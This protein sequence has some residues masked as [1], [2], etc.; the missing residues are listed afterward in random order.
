MLSEQRPRAQIANLPNSAQL[1]DTPFHSPKLH[2][3]PCSSVGM[4]QGTNTPTAMAIHFSLA[5]TQAKCIN[6]SMI[7]NMKKNRMSEYCVTM[8]IFVWPNQQHASNLLQ[9]KHK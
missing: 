5:M 4:W 1:G 2:P 3:G 9:D 7:L 8:L 6:T